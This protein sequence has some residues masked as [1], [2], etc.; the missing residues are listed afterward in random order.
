MLKFAVKRA[1]D[2][3]GSPPEVLEYED[4]KTRLL[5]RICWQ[6]DWIAGRRDWFL[7]CRDAGR[8]SGLGHDTAAKRLEMFVADGHLRII[9]KGGMNGE[10]EATVYDYVTRE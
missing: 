10:R 2:D 3:E 1:L 6:I 8:F 7:S 5:L 9:S 4:E